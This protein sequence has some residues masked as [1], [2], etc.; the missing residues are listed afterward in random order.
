MIS[1]SEA[2]WLVAVADRAAAQLCRR[3]CGRDL[4]REDVR[5]DL[6]VDLLSRFGAY[7]ASRGT[8]RTFAALCF[9]HRSARLMRTA[10]R[11]RLA[12]H[13]VELDGSAVK[14]G[15]TSVIDTLDASEGFGA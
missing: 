5:Q 12:R 14:G 15:T 2:V 7:D 6:L 11:E 13:P 4:D 9:K 3:S 10:Y 8:L 1:R